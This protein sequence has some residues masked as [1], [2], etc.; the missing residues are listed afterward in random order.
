MEAVFFIGMGIC[1]FLGLLLVGK[2]QKQRYDWILAG[3]LLTSALHLLYFYVSI[4]TGVEGI[5]KY[6]L[7]AGALLAYLS[8]PVLYLYFRE[9]LAI[10]PYRWFHY[11]VHLMPFLFMLTAFYFFEHTLGTIRVAIRNVVIISRGEVPWYLGH[12]SLIMAF[13][14][15]SYLFYVIYLLYKHQKHVKEEFSYTDKV[16]LNWMRHWLILEFVGF[17]IT[18]AIIW[19]AD[20]Q[21]ITLVTSFKVISVV[22][23]VNVFVIG[24]FG[25]RQGVIFQPVQPLPDN[26]QPEPAR[27]QTKYAKSTLDAQLIDQSKEKLEKIMAEDKLY[28]NPRLSANDLAEAMGVSRHLLTQL[29]NEEIGSN[30]YDYVNSYRL[31]EFKDRVSDATNDH[32]TLLGIALDSGFNSKSSFNL[33]FKKQEGITPTQ[34]RKKIMLESVESGPVRAD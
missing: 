31:R 21:Y 29:L 1:V 24:L 10:R 9:L 12:Y 17:W 27:Q 14:C 33:I 6:L 5:P 30:F 8:A 25:V 2:K 28:L 23:A 20:F 26:G 13:C 18:F 32:L 15:V 34:Y 7:V 22:V 4:V 19:V 16:T 11:A 3:W